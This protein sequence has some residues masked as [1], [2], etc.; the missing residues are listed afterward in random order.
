MTGEASAHAEGASGKRSLHAREPQ[1]RGAMTKP[2]HRVNQDEAAAR[3][4]ASPQHLKMHD[5]NV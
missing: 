1:P 5:G 2:G 3:F 4:I